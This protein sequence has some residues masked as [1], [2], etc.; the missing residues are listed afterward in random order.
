M[1]AFLI[2]TGVAAGV[3]LATICRCRMMRARLRFIRCRSRYQH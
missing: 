2:V 3:V 1:D